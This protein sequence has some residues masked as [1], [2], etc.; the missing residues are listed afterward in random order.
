MGTMKRTMMKR[1]LGNA[2]DRRALGEMSM[3]TNAPLPMWRA[4]FTM[5]RFDRYRS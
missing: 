2:T 1:A 4:E 3:T 5:S